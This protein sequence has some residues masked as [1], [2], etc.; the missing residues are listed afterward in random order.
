MKIFRAVFSP[1]QVNT[2]II[3]GN[4]RECIVIDCGC[5][6]E[7][8]EKRLIEDEKRGIK[9]GL[10]IESGKKARRGR[11]KKYRPA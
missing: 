11:P 1:I 5:Y 9:T 2:Y 6:G 4:D 10:E 7:E 3:T 8:E